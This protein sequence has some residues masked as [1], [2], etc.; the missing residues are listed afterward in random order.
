MWGALLSGLGSF[1][2]A[3]GGGLGKV[4]KEIGGGIVKGGQKIGSEF[5]ERIGQMREGGGS[6]AAPMTPGFNPGASMPK[7]GGDRGGFAPRSSPGNPLLKLRQA[8]GMGEDGARPAIA[9][10]EPPRLPMPAL[11]LKPPMPLT[12]TQQSGHPPLTGFDTNTGRLEGSPPPRMAPPLTGVNPMSGQMDNQPPMIR[13]SVQITDTA[14]R[15]APSPVPSLAAPQMGAPRDASFDGREGVPLPGRPNRGGPVPWSPYEQGKYDAWAKHAKRDADGNFDP[16]GG[17]NR[18]WKSILQNGLLG[19]AQYA[20]SGDWGKMLGGAIGGV[21]G[22]AVNPQAGYEHVWDAG[23]GARMMEDQGRQDAQVERQR[24]Q[25][26]G[27][28][29]E[30][31]A[32]YRIDHMK[33]QDRVAEGNLS[34]QERIADSQIRLNEARQQAALRGTPAQADLYN[35][36]TNRIEKV[37]VYP[38]GR[39]EVLGI[40]GSAITAQQNREAQ[41]YRDAANRESREYIAQLPARSRSGSD[42]IP[43]EARQEFMRLNRMKDDANA[44]WTRAKTEAEPDKK[45]ALEEQ[46]RAALENYNRNLKD[47]GSVY[48]EHYETGKGDGGWGYAKPRTGGGQSGQAA[49]MPAQA[50]VSRRAIEE[51]AKEKGVSVEEAAQRFAAKGIQVR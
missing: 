50:S 39:R 1:G 22:S 29:D 11:N 21:G 12:P 44:L 6:G 24:K 16:K 41:N 18:N 34:R 27:G 23:H 9:D 3:I 40:S 46:A 35:P 25:R 37:N 8:A 28:L 45:A 32:R 19:A 49:P 4:G 26:M 17:T 13:D 20:D 48:G 7:L 31:Y 5:K 10:N 14:P 33:N 36:G 30:D 15:L 43:V 51:Y 38:D 2:K 42:G 47:F